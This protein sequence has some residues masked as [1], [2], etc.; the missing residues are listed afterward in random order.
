[1]DITRRKMN[2]IVDE[3]LTFLFSVGADDV[4]VNMKKLPDRYQLSLRGNFNLDEVSKVQRLETIL[5]PTSRYE[6]L[7]DFYWELA[8]NTAEGQ[9]SE[10]QLV[11]QM[12]DGAELSIQN[13]LVHIQLYKLL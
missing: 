7:E 12:V 3:L 4:Q 2:K 6:G 13:N 5:H 10:L 1:M 11:A 9:D 8:G